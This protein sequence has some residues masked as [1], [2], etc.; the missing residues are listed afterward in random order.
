MNYGGA[1][2]IPYS[3]YSLTLNPK[4]TIEMN[5]VNHQQETE[6]PK[7]TRKHKGV[8]MGGGGV[9]NAEAYKWHPYFGKWQW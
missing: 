2:S 5:W 1:K 4:S 9:K 3:L 6:T 8:S 7:P